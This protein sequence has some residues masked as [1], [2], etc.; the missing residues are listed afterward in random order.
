[1]QGSNGPLTEQ[2]LKE[3][4]DLRQKLDSFSAT[5]F[6]ASISIIGIIVVMILSGV[7][8]VWGIVISETAEHNL[9]WREVSRLSEAQKNFIV[10]N[11]S[12]DNLLKELEIRMRKVESSS[13]NGK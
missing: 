10:N 1:M 2:A 6:T 11:I 4:A 13:G 3:I 12:Q 5:R 8:G 9:L 7:A